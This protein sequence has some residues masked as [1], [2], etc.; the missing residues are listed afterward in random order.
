MVIPDL[1]DLPNWDSITDEWTPNQWVEAFH[2]VATEYVV[3]KWANATRRDPR[4]DID[5]LKG[6]ATEELVRASR[7]WPAWAAAHDGGADSRVK[8]WSYTKQRITFR[9]FDHYKRL[10]GRTEEQRAIRMT[11]VSLDAPMDDLNIALELPDIADTDTTLHRDIVEALA[12]LTPLEQLVVSMAYLDDLTVEEITSVL[13]ISRSAGRALRRRAG[14]NLLDRVSNLVSE[15]Q[16][17]TPTLRST[18][19]L[20]GHLTSW[21]RKTH[22]MDVDSY[23]QHSLACFAADIETV[24]AM[25]RTI[26][27]DAERSAFKSGVAS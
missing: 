10:T 11:T 1:Y 12:Q 23:L 15:E 18:A 13:G 22:G 8:F 17:D 25:L 9:L 14:R 4:L 2:T 19:P 21:V 27:I 20:N 24:L 26:H 6:I 5:E 7:D 16:R 3:G